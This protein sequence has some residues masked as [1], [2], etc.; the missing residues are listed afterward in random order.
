MKF[1]YL[2]DDS[3]KT[4]APFFSPVMLSASFHSLWMVT[5]LLLLFWPRKELFHFVGTNKGPMTFFLILTAT[6][7]VNGYLNLRCGRGEMIPSDVLS[8]YRKE[9]VTFEKERGFFQYGLIA[10]L[11]HTCLLMMPF[12]PLFILT[13]S[14]SGINGSVLLKATFIV[15]TAS[16]LCRMFGFLMYLFWG[17]FRMEGYLCSRLFIVIFFFVT[18]AFAPSFS[19]IRI[20]YALNQGPSHDLTMDVAQSAQSSYVTYMLTA[21]SGNLFL[22]L[23]SQMLVHRRAHKEK[24]S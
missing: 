23:L 6:L 15:Y 7:I 10:F 12:F 19:P 11:L 20:L 9:P 18:T 1:D 4:L 22:I 3:E 2:T 16:L 5:G 17:R 24:A 21:I 14:I 13:A 8:E